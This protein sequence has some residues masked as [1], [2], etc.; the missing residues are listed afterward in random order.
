LPDAV[1]EQCQASWCAFFSEFGRPSA[2][3]APERPA[4]AG[5]HAVDRLAAYLGRHA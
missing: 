1:V 5:A 4:S 3:F 2:N